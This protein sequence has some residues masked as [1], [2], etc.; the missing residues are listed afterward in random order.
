MFRRY[1]VGCSDDLF[2]KTNVRSLKRQLHRRKATAASRVT[3]VGGALE[4]DTNR[5]FAY[6]LAAE[7]NGIT[8]LTV[9]DSERCG[10]KRFQVFFVPF[11]LV[12]LSTIIITQVREMNSTRNDERAAYAIRKLERHRLLCA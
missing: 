8:I 7:N 10:L 6:L 3:R 4:T 11:A 9:R 1:P 5:V 12:S 2:A